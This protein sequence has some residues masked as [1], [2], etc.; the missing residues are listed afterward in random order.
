MQDFQSQ[1]DLIKSLQRGEITQ[2]NYH[3]LVKL[4]NYSYPDIRGEYSVNLSYLEKEFKE[5]T[6]RRECIIDGNMSQ[7]YV[8][9]ICIPISSDWELLLYELDTSYGDSFVS[10]SFKTIKV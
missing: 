8:T 3:D 1:V 5:S 4:N 9:A 6:R 7:Q 2:G 10:Y